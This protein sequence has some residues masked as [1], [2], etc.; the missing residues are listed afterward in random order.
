MFITIRP[1]GGIGYENK[2]RDNTPRVYAPER[3]DCGWHGHCSLRRNSADRRANRDLRASRDRR[4]GRNRHAAATAAPAAT[5]TPVATAVP[6]A[7]AT[8]ASLYKEA[9]MLADLVKAGKLP[10]VDQR[11]PKNPW[12]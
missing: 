9:P 5:A 12:S 11:L 10:P 8:P 1:N 3:P 4:A 7:T 2:T 6:V